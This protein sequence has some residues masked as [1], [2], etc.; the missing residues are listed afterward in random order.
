MVVCRACSDDMR[1]TD[2]LSVGRMIYG[3][4]KV[5]HH[6]LAASCTSVE[7]DLHN[8]KASVKTGGN[9]GMVTNL[10]GYETMAREKRTWAWSTRW[11]PSKMNSNLMIVF[12]KSG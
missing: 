2:A 11:R 6:R 12:G 8:P 4:L 9:S 1:C 3:G 5:P 10:G 7:R